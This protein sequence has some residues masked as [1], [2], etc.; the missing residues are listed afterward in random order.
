VGQEHARRRERARE[1]PAPRPAAVPPTSA[2]DAVIGLQRAAGNRAVAVSLERGRRPAAPVVQR[3]H[4]DGAFDENLLQ[5][6]DARNRSTRALTPHVYS[7]DVH[8]DLTRGATQVDLVVK[9]RF[10]TP[11]DQQIP[12]ADTAR[13]T[14][15]ANMCA[16]VEA[17]WGSKYVF[18]TKTH[19]PPPATGTGTA[20]A[21]GA[22]APTPVPASG[23]TA[24]PAPGTAAPPAAVDVRLP[25][26]FKATPEYS[27]TDDGTMPIVHVHPQTE[28]ADSSR[29]GKRIDSGN[30]FMNMGDYDTNDPNEAVKTAAHEY[31]HLLG[32]PDEYSQSN[33]QMHKLMHQASPTLAAGEDQRLDDAATKYMVLRAMGPSLAQHARAGAARAT[34]ALGAKRAHLEQEVRAAIAGLW[35]DAAVID[36]VKAEVTPQLTAG[37]HPALAGRVDAL[38]RHQ[39]AGVDTGKIAR[40]IVKQEIGA[41]SIEALVLGALRKAIVG[42]QRVVIPITNASGQTSTMTVQIGTSQTVNK[43]A[44]GGALNQAAEKVAG[45]TMDA[46]AGK[47]GKAPPS[48]RPSGSFVSELQALTATW[49]AGAD[50]LATQAAAIKGKAGDDYRAFAFDATSTADETQLAK[51]LGGVAETLSSSL[52]GEAINTF[53]NSTFATMMQG[54]IDA[55]TAAVQTEIDSHRTATPTGTSA[56]PVAAPDPRVAAAVAKVSA[57]M[58]AL[59]AAPGTAVPGAKMTGET[60]AP[61]TQH[62]SFTVMSM[63]GSGNEGGL[64]IDYLAKILDQFNT[65]FKK[66]EED[67]F[68]T[69]TT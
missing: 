66:P 53:L 31:G 68:K 15:I 1:H 30:W 64:R 19:P 12:A 29:P 69:E 25:V 39:G 42:A 8:Y 47:G 28:A 5:P 48:L 58:R 55:I 24:P 20:P 45:A 33:A 59:Q 7:Q 13:R 56:A 67:A 6:Y 60:A 50:T 41:K 2:H 14:Y 4:V 37:G 51:F 35:S 54:Q 65:Q 11:D 57:K 63:M 27:P 23:T 18:V 36:A 21:P 38:L 10:V 44:S 22:A 17:A 43:A 52:G 32:I 3:V 61:T 16:G 62:T 26:K 9:I 46:P 49:T 34:K 40:T